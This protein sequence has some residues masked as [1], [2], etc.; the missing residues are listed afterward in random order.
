MLC[1]LLLTQGISENLCTF[2]WKTP[3]EE[4]SNI[5]QYGESSMS[6]FPI[7]G[8]VSVANSKI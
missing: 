1:E 5:F 2:L 3:I 6:M 8:G 7:I 4:R